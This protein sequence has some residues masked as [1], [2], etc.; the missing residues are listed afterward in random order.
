MTAAVSEV[1]VQ[2]LIH[3]SPPGGGPAPGSGDTLPSGCERGGPDWGGGGLGGRVRG[4]AQTADGLGQRPAE[5]GSWENRLRGPPPPPERL[6][7]GWQ[8]RQVT[9]TCAGRAEAAQ[10]PRGSCEEEDEDLEV[11]RRLPQWLE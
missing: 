11:V 1:Y 5:R 6:G 3:P 10:V 4:G 2:P 7:L 8:C 9:G